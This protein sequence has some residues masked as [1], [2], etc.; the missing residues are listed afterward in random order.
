MRGKP[1]CGFWK[2]YRG[3]DIRY[4]HR[5][6][7][8]PQPGFSTPEPNAKPEQNEAAANNSDASCFGAMDMP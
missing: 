1:L 2:N 8:H 7:L 6:M 5:K 4:H 3:A